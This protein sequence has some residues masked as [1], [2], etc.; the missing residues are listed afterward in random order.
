MFLLSIVRLRQPIDS[1]RRLTVAG[2]EQCERFLRI[3]FLQPF[4]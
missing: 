1:T 4:A 3:E 2:I